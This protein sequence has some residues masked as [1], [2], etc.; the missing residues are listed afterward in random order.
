MKDGG[1]CSKSTKVEKNHQS[2]TEKRSKDLD[3]EMRVYY[4]CLKSE[5]SIIEYIHMKSEI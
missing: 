1:N 2:F 5:G 3:L 4:S